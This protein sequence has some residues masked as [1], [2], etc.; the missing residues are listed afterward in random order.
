MMP[1]DL[2]HHIAAEVA[3][4]TAGYAVADAL[5]LAAIAEAATNNIK[6]A[7]D[8]A[9]AAYSTADAAL[10]LVVA[11]YAVADACWRSRP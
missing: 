6:T 2:A 9:A 5:H 11:Q 8:F 3:A 4:T 1:I 10:A 7:D